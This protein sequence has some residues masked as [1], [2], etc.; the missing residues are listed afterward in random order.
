MLYNFLFMAGIGLLMVALYECE[1]LPITPLS[2]ATQLLFLLQVAMEL[3]TIVV[4]PIALKLFA[5]KKM[6]QKLIKGGASTLLR[7]GTFRLNLLG[8]P[9]L[10]N[11]FLYYQCMSPAFGYLAII[12]FLCLFFVYP[13]MDRCLAETSDPESSK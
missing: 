8:L 5:I 1:L 12:L 9:M 10:I 4:I 3:L 13:S 7:W 2:E 6:R 11:V